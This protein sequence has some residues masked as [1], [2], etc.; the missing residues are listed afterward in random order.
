VDGR[1]LS[2]PILDGQHIDAGQP[3]AELL[4]GLLHIKR[5][6]AAAELECRRQVLGELQ[7]GSRPEAL[8]QALAIV[9]GFKAH[10]EYARSRFARFK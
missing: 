10:S 8:M 5:A 7:A 4:Y 6:G 2:L 1:L 3:I 9:E